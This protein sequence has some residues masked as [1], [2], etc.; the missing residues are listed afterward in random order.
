MPQD[1]MNRLLKDLDKLRF[2]LRYYEATSTS[3][4]YIKLDYGVCG[5]IRI[6]DHK[7]KDKYKYRYN[8]MLGLDKSY[9]EDDRFY[10]SID[11]YNKLIED[12]KTYREEQFNKYG[13]RYYELIVNN[14]NEGKNKKGFWKYSKNYNE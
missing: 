12:V 8:L 6:A 14:K 1:Y 2:I 11:D 5:S 7:G 9:V 13:F 4:C 10:Y 3:S